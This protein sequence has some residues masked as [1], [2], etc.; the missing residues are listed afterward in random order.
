MRAAFGLACWRPEV[1]ST[2]MDDEPTKYSGIRHCPEAGVA[3]RWGGDPCTTESC[4]SRK[5]EGAQ[6]G[7]SAADAGEPHRVAVRGTGVQPVAQFCAPAPK[8]VAGLQG[9]PR[10]AEH[11]S[12]QKPA[13]GLADSWGAKLAPAP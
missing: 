6:S 9:E 7:A 3:A 11:P 1:H 2:G 10:I 5:P 8:L 13:N 12:A 4:L